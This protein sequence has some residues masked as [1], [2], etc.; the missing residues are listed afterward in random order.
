MSKRARAAYL[1][2]RP[3]PA[4]NATLTQS[5]KG[6]SLSLNIYIVV[7]IGP[8]FEIITSDNLNRPAFVFITHEVIKYKVMI[9]RN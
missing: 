4:S 5:G 8:I 1:P 3:V 2:A 6:H 7:L 9:L